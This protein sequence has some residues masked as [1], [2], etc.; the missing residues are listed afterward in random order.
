[1]KLY[2]LVLVI[3]V[4]LLI[5]CQESESFSSITPDKIPILI[6]SKPEKYK[7]SYERLKV[8]GFKII[9]RVPPVFLKESKTCALEKIGLSELGCIEAHK[10]CFREVL[11]INS[12]CII[13]EEDWDYSLASGIFLK[14]IMNYYSYYISNNLD[15]LW[16]GHCG[17][18]CTHA[19]IIGPKTC[20]YLLGEDYCSS[21]LDIKLYKLC[22]ERKIK[23]FKVKNDNT[24]KNFFGGGIILQ[25]RKNN[26]GMH[27]HYNTR[28][29]MWF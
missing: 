5:Y 11:N 4:F 29:K 12:P 9:K 28:T 19:Y 25:D 24:N 1:M 17:N 20:N 6:I 23:C 2:I 8:L 16:L 27:D 26:I 22:R 7:K 21:P 10:S 3:L 13:L 15:I 18:A 14:K